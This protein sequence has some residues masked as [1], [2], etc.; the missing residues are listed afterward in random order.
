MAAIKPLKID[1]AGQ[2]AVLQTS[3]NDF[4]DILVGGT[5]ANTAMGARTALGV[6]IGSDI[7]SY[8]AD[9]AALAA[10]SASTGFPVRTA[11]N[12]FAMRQ[13]AV[14]AQLAITNP[15][16]IAGNPTLD[17]NTLT[18]AGT[19]TF[20]KVTRD[21]YGRVAG[22]TP[23]VAADIT[24]LV[25]AT[26]APINNATFT[27]TTTLAAD[28]ASA[29][30]AAT[31][32]YVDAIAA[33][34]RIKDAVHLLASANVVIATGTLLT[35]DGVVTVAGN[36]VL[37]TAQTTG[38]EN[39]VYIAASGA[40]VRATDFDSAAGEVMGGATFWVNEGTTW[41]DTA[42]TLTTNDPMVIGTTSL[43]FT[44]SS[45]LGQVTAGGGL[46]KTGSQIDVV[47]SARIQINSDNID[48][49]SGV[50]GAGTYTKLTVDTYG[51][52]TGG[53]TATP[54]DISAQPVDAGLTSISALTG[55][56]AVHATAT[57][58][59]VM[60]TATGT[61]GRLVVTNGDGAAG[62]PTYD[63]SSG[64]IAA[65]G[66]YQSVT[67]DTYG[68]VTAG[69]IASSTVTSDNF[70]N[71][72]ASSIVIG[73]AVYA[74]TTTDQVKLAIANAS[75]P[76][77]AIG[78]VNAASISASA[79]GSIAFSGVIA[80][81]TGQW[82]VVTGQ[83]GGL[84]PGAM[85]FLSNTTAGALTTTAPTTGF[86]C[87]VGRAMSTTKLALRFDPTIQL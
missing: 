76:A 23:V 75:A 47:G 66:I 27:G 12:T 33:G 24:G 63:L 85:Y 3:S 54:S 68:R 11:T 49:V 41:G 59:F 58:T 56:G 62:N 69:T 67:V 61:A 4:V 38:S 83:T 6:A 80:A 48:L 45:G 25:N 46:T 53:T 55:A 71:A 74:F 34:Q 81:T 7:Q 32:Q 79:A 78:L 21:T 17:L 22:T 15:A 72:E 10:L 20:L 42:W 77:Q 9:L 50:V 26:Y 87:A 39:G 31:K 19:G 30:Q 43:T 65:P 37:L 44:Q 52:V 73:R 28:P 13:I 82:D 51:R 60:R 29:L 8:S 36:R 64:V 57:D 14:A 84:T 1:S 35:V 40:W 2:V 18:D 70:T 16:G 86:L 5:G